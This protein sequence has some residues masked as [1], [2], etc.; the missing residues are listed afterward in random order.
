M[1][2]WMLGNTQW[3]W[4]PTMAFAITPHF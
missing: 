1:G 4:E 2:W 3:R